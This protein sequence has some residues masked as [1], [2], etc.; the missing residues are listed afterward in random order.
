MNS[1]TLLEQ[2]GQTILDKHL[3]E[4]Q[5]DN[6]KSSNDPIYT[7]TVQL[8]QFLKTNSIHQVYS[9]S[10][11]YQKCSKILEL[12]DTL[13]EDIESTHGALSSSIGPGSELFEAYKLMTFSLLN[14]T[15]S[16]KPIDIKEL[17]EKYNTLKQMFEDL[18]LKQDISN[19]LSNQTELLD[20]SSN[21]LLLKIITEFDLPLQ[22]TENTLIQELHK[23]ISQLPDENKEIDELTLTN[24]RL[25]CENDKLRVENESLILEL[26]C[27][28]RISDEFNNQLNTLIVFCTDP[29]GI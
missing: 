13:V 1:G 3:N 6:E 17:Q 25:Q 16:F 21:S 24:Q 20:S 7:H 23:K 14:V 11:D 10:F 29:P 15:K 22:T 19:T 12:V 28:Q 27:N 8:S 2:L 26:Q 9:A 4:D 5:N 18:Q